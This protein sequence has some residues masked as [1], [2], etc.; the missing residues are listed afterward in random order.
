MDAKWLGP[1]L[2][3]SELGKDFYSF[4]SLDGKAVVVKRINGAHLKVYKRSSSRE[5]SLSISTPQSSKQLSESVLP[6]PSSLK[7][8]TSSACH[9][10]PIAAD[11]CDLKTIGLIVL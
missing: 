3:S 7:Q 10:Q 9:K 2:L 6:Q 8:L 1:F 5:Q 4:A 11:A